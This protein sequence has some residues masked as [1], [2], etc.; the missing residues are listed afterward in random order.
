MVHAVTHY[1]DPTGSESLG[2]L[3]DLIRAE[4]EY[5]VANELP[6]LGVGVAVPGVVDPET[7]TLRMSMRL[8]WT[9]MPLAALLRD[10]LD[11][12]VL[13]DNDISALT[14]FTARARNAPTSCWSR[15]ARE[16]G[17][18]WCSTAPRTGEPRA[19]R[20]NWATFR[21]CRTVPSA[22]AATG[23]AWRRR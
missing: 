15:S 21:S 8:G 17:W 7:G 11:L 5:A 3:T 2:R 10:A 14:G 20:E 6:L 13:V 18:A 12:P 23:V 4:V 19:R 9:G 16:S 1:F 22:A